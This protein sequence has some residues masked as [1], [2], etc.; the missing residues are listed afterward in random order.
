[1]QCCAKL[2]RPKYYRT[3]SLGYAAAFPLLVRDGATCPSATRSSFTVTR[4]RVCTLLS[5]RSCSV[6]GLPAGLL[7]IPLI[8]CHV[9]YVI[10]Q[11]SDIS[12]KKFFFF[13]KFCF[14]SFKNPFWSVL[15]MWLL[16]LNDSWGL[17]NNYFQTQPDF[18]VLHHKSTDSDLCSWA[19][20]WREIWS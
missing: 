20:I 5:L 8:S 7:G 19:Q 11:E 1:M 9:S 10:L 12:K 6:A 18:A 3:L 17:F 15:N 13:I 16:M 2:N 14:I 4:V